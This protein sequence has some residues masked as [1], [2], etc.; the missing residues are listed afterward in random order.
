MNLWK[1]GRK[2]RRNI[3]ELRV[4]EKRPFHLIMLLGSQGQ[5]FSTYGLRTS[6]TSIKWKLV[7]LTDL[8]KELMAA[9]G[10]NGRKG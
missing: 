9:R 8:E 2:E 3:I 1:K 10:K 4:T 7:R 6:S 5:W